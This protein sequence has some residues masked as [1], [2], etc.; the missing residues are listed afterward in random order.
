MLQT[1]D[2]TK[3]IRERVGGFKGRL[4]PGFL[5]R[6]LERLIRQNELNEMLR[7]AYPARGSEFSQRI[8]EHLDIRLE[9]D[10][11]SLQE[12]PADCPVV[13]ASNHPLGGLDGI[14]LVAVLGARYGDENIA[15]L[16]ND[17]LMNVE[18]LRDVFLPVNK[19]GRQGREGVRE[20]AHAYASGRQIVVFPA[21]LVSRL[22]DDGQIRDLEWQKTFVSKA[23]EYG[24]P[25]VPVR[26]EALNSMRFYRIAR[27]RKKLGLKINIEQALL[28]QEVVKSRGKS[29]KITF[30]TPVDVSEMSSCGMKPAEIAAYIRGLVV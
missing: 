15:V 29:F 10:D 23:L 18:P 11:A 7:Y 12:I 1:I 25:V 13:F 14:A 21:G 6:R 28:P 19:Y 24:R 17:M 8:L 26:F 9:V 5:L 16:V 30:L 27:R 3:I 20:I 4:L 2:L 22:H